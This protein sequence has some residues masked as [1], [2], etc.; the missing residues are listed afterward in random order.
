MMAFSF[1]LCGDDHV[2]AVEEKI[3]AGQG[4][5]LRTHL[6]YILFGNA[7]DATKN[8]PVPLIWKVSFPD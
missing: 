7:I 1:M 8:K 4:C 2:M 6:F 5:S 3:G